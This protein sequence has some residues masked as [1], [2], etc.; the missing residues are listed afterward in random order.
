MWH[1]WWSFIQAFSGKPE[2]NHAEK[3]GIYGRII[4]I[5]IFKEQDGGL[6]N[7][8]V[9]SRMGT[10]G[11][12]LLNLRVPYSGGTTLTSRTVLSGV[13]WLVYVSCMNMPAVCQRDILAE[14]AY[15]RNYLS[16]ISSMWPGWCVLFPK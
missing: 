6:W 11:G 10:S 14:G 12:L 3:L 7:G 8:L 4:F 2:G 13:N 9:W 15:T 16:L 5:L 1:V